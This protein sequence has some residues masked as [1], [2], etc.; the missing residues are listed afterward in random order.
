MIKKI[1]TIDESYELIRR[2]KTETDGISCDAWVKKNNKESLLK[3][4]TKK[5]CITEIFW[6]LILDKLYI[7]RVSY[8]F[9]RTTDK[10]YRL[11]TENYNPNHYPTY[12]LKDLIIEYCQQKNPTQKIT[13]NHIYD[14]YNLDDLNKIY[15]FFYKKQYSEKCI[16][17]LN[18]K[19]YLHFVIQ[20][21][22]GNS[23]LN[24]KN[25]EIYIKDEPKISPFYDLRNYGYLKLVC[26]YNDF[27]LKYNF[28]KESEWIKPEKVFYTFL[29]NASRNQLEIFLNYME[30]IK[31]INTKPIFEQL[32]E[33][34]HQFISPILKFQLEKKLYSNSIIAEKIMKQ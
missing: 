26:F 34:N 22:L 33:E 19:T 3:Y 16:N 6:G 18:E 10:T 21:L 1:I 23:D 2:C 32:E 27:L 12:R 24:P 14:L 30:K 5:E 29:K 31:E 20:L 4:G 7:D 9:C 11:M 8:E 13:V 28:Q 15:E 25:I 17:E